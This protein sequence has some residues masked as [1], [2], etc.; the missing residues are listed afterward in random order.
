[1]EHLKGTL[2][3]LVQGGWL[4]MKGAMFFLPSLSSLENQTTCLR[5]CL[6]W[7]EESNSVLRKGSLDSRLKWMPLFWSSLFTTPQKHTGHFKTCLP[8]STLILLTLIL[9]FHMFTGK[10]IR[11]R[12]LLLIWHAQPKHPKFWER[13]NSKEWL[14]AWSDAIEQTFHIFESNELLD[15]TSREFSSPLPLCSLYK[16]EWFS[17]YRISLGVRIHIIT[18]LTIPFGLYNNSD[19]CETQLRRLWYIGSLLGPFC[20][21]GTRY[22]SCEFSLAL[23]LLWWCWQDRLLS[24]AIFFFCLQPATLPHFVLLSFCC[25]CPFHFWLNPLAHTCLKSIWFL[26][27]TLS[28]FLYIP[29]S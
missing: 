5:R 10:A 24:V 8:K 20:F 21:Q 4:E 25:L 14:E 13:R 22:V 1:M 11:W 26:A 3:L 28:C 7:T 23:S 9:R 15:T 16:T 17:F 29:C 18:T 12:M 6:H 2:E 19:I 27:T